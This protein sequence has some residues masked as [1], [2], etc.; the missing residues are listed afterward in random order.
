MGLDITAYSNLRAVGDHT[1]P[2]EWCED[3]GHIMAYAYAC[4]PASF[5]GI[6]VLRHEAANSG[7]DLIIGGCYAV[8]PETETHKFRAGSYSGYGR[9]RSD[10]A[11]QFNPAPIT[12]EGLRR[13][14][15]EPNPEGPFYAL[16]WFADNE[17]CI[18]ELAAAEL[19]ADFRAHADRYSPEDPTPFDRY[20]ELYQDWTRA[21]ELA[22][23][24][25]LVSFH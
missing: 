22:A 25:G 10:L 6:P 16:I 3:E 11:E 18:G 4:F 9:W 13:S 12:G 5:Q 15:A 7:S 24:G 1:D 21:F 2:G 20:R 14:M 17:G 23:D 19:L 8:T